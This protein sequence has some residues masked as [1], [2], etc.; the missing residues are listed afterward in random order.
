[1]QCRRFGRTWIE[2]LFWNSSLGLIIPG[3]RLSC[4]GKYVEDTGKRK[5]CDDSK[6]QRIATETWN[7]AHHSLHRP[8][9][10][11]GRAE[12]MRRFYPLL[13]S[14]TSQKSVF[15]INY[16]KIPIQRSCNE[17][18][19]KRVLPDFRHA[20]I[21]KTRPGGPRVPRVKDK[22][23]RESENGCQIGFF[24]SCDCDSCTLWIDEVAR[25]A[26]RFVG[27]QAD[28]PTSV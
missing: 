12:W 26:T 19:A 8:G 1:M 24:E 3:T 20:S 13:Y 14:M 4:N 25:Q 27:R 11:D 10:L 28:D 9:I 15:A 16:V 2:W 17:H 21:E 5:C 18:R 22:A 23:Q 7:L 6:P